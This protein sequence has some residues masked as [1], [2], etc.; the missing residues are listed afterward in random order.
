MGMV[1]GNDQADMKP[2][3]IRRALLGLLDILSGALQTMHA[4]IPDEED[5]G[6]AQ[7]NTVLEAIYQT[8]LVVGKLSDE[9]NKLPQ[10]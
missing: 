2:W 10:N 3:Y 1:W 9:I 8:Q 4:L 5:G 6:S 7:L